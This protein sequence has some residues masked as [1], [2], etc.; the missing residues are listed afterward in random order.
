MSLAL[1]VPLTVLQIL[2]GKVKVY[3]RGFGISEC[4]LPIYPKG[5][6]QS[7]GLTTFDRGGIAL[8]AGDEDFVLEEDSDLG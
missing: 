1:R 3:H 6:D 5:R 7:A 8:R 4:P 2:F